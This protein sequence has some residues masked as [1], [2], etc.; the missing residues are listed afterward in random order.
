MTSIPADFVT[1]REALS[2]GLGIANTLV[3]FAP[4]AIEKRKIQLDDLG[5][6]AVSNFITRVELAPDYS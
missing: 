1:L 5:F 3:E 4:T 2:K 6:L